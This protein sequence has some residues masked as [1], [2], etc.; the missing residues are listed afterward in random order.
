MDRKPSIKIDYEAELNPQQ[1]AVVTAEGGPALVIA[2]AGSGKTRTITYRVAHLVAA[3]EDPHRILLVTFT[4]KAAREML[5]RVERLIGLDLKRLW[6]GT[7]HHVGNLTLRRHA[8]LLDYSASYSILDR[9]DSK[10][11]LETCLSDMGIPK[12]ERRFPKGDVLQDIVSH[13]VNTEKPIEEV[14]TGRYPFFKEFTE[15]IL[16]IARHY[17]EKKKRANL[18][19]YDDLLS[20]WKRLLEEHP[21]VKGI[22]TSRFRHILVDEYQD[23]NKLQADLVDLL[24]SQ[25]RNLVVVGD[26]AQ[27]I[28]AF[29]G[30]HF[31]NIMEFPKR[32]PD[33]KVYKLETNYRSTP[34][35]LDLANSA[36][37][38]NEKQF[39]KNLKAIRKGGE[40]PI[41][42]PL[43][44]VLQQADHVAK[45]ILTLRE[46]GILLEE[47][48][49]LYR[50]HYHSME[51][52]LELTRRGIPYTIRSGLRFFEQAHIKDVVSYLKI[53][54]NPL[55]ELA[56]T[57]ILKQLPLIGRVTA[58]RLFRHLSSKPDPLAS[59]GT[60][61]TR[62]LLPKGAHPGWEEF[63]R[64]MKRLADPAVQNN[65]SSQINLI[66][67][68][69]YQDY[70]E[71]AYPNFRDRIE[72]LRQLAQF[73]GRYRSL[74]NFLSELALVGSVESETVLA[75]A[76]EEE[77]K[78]VLSTIHQAKGLEWRAV[79]LI[80]LAEGRFPPS[81][82]L[83]HPENE[84]E[85]RRLF[86]VAVTRAKDL[87]FFSYPIV[88]EG[89]RGLTLM[90]P[91][92][93]LSELEP[94]T[95]E[96]RLLDRDIETL[97]RQA[98][99]EGA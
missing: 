75:G 23:T 30:A 20:L 57:R 33:A 66:L 47:I 44:D 54:A 98:D 63:V 51:L 5:H 38:H 14:V 82:S 95:Y 31:A 52:Q 64:L 68:G 8:R 67:E 79:F 89:W 21:E 24:G 42:V 29:R 19:D 41:L 26:D 71:S 87:L 59:L 34:E 76:Q 4:N 48:A 27:S 9:E 46:E 16:A 12:K 83:D 58:E 91:S 50:S 69:G 60:D 17:R 28:Y 11:L 49:V 85:E 13:A 96:R 80:W 3:G 92:R 40:R 74:D 45:K 36:I 10:D 25:H 90:K 2:G 56:W 6:G 7:F 39:P 72:D 77:G 78:V 35:I 70:L 88:S 37:G 97:I 62:L 18:V 22:Y 93:F 43:R 81:R 73:A 15:I 86:Y 94:S 55:D 65:P 32:Y 53:L 84:E 99:G 61:E 1:R